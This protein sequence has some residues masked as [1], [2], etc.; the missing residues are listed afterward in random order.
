M[1]YIIK[2]QNGCWVAG[3]SESS[4]P[5]TVVFQNAKVFKNLDEA[6]KIKEKLISKNNHRKL[7]LQ[8][9]EYEAAKREVK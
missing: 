7:N 4:L 9:L 1:E 6:N 8:I 5:R 3:W 2:I